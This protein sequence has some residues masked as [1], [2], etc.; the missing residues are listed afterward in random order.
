M[1]NTTGIDGS[2]SWSDLTFISEKNI[3]EITDVEHIFQQ[4]YFDNVPCIPVFIIM[5]RYP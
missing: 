1:A 4:I 3:Y 2:D 5:S